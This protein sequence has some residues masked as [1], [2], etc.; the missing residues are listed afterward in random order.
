M[1]DA[2]AEYHPGATV[3]WYRIQPTGLTTQ[4]WDHF[5]DNCTYTPRLTN[6]SID[7]FQNF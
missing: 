4:S 2:Y 7:W 6:T 1:T 3:S 5:I